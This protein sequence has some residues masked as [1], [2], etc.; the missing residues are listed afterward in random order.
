M[1]NLVHLI[2]VQ[3]RLQRIAAH[4]LADAEPGR[5]L[6]RLLE[7]PPATAPALLELDAVAP[8]QAPRSAASAPRRRKVPRASPRRWRLPGRRSDRLTRWRRSVPPANRRAM[9]VKVSRGPPTVAAT[10]SNSKINRT[11]FTPGQQR[12]DA[13][14]QHRQRMYEGGPA[15]IW[16]PVVDHQTLCMFNFASKKTM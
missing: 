5:R 8:A 11:P 16:P 6:R 15:R 7:H 2:M 10:A 14:V 4:P 12:A 3:A 9:S 13:A 1:L